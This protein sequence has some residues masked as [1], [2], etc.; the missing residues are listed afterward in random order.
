MPSDAYRRPE[1][2][3]AWG[4]FTMAAVGRSFSW[5]PSFAADDGM[6]IVGTAT[7]L[8]AW[9][10]EG[11]RLLWSSP[12]KTH[13]R[14]LKGAWRQGDA[15]YVQVKGGL[16]RLDA[17]TGRILWTRQDLLDD[18]ILVERR[19]DGNLY[20]A[21][22][23]PAVAE[24]LRLAVRKRYGDG[25]ASWVVPHGRMHFGISRRYDLDTEREEF[26]VWELV[27]GRWR[28]ILEYDG[29]LSP[30]EKDRL[31]AR[32]RFSTWMRQRLETWN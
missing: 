32:Y 24:S 7:G 29:G 11:G 30:A 6:A 10:L 27:D 26:A 17:A 22:F 25:R 9:D 31:F 19:T 21:G 16:S 14:N 15:V 3:G 4:Q 8:E 23:Y 5:S 20:V 1:E 13:A 18:V 2:H 28:W 12:L